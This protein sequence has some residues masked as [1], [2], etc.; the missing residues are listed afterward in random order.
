ME[1]DQWSD[2]AETLF[3]T[4]IVE[5]SS[6]DPSTKKHANFEYLDT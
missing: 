5:L 2:I 1:L 6:S 4:L 3:E